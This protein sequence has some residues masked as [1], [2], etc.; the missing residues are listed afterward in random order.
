[1][2][3]IRIFRVVVLV[4]LALSLIAC[5]KCPAPMVTEQFV[6]KITTPFRVT[7]DGSV[8]SIAKGSD[9][10]VYLGGTF[11]SASLVSGTGVLV[12][13]YLGFPLNME[14]PQVDGSIFVATSDGLGGWYIGGD[15]TAVGDVSRER[16]A[17]LDASANLDLDWDPGA[18]GFVY[19][20]VVSG[21]NVYVSGTFT[22]VAGVAQNYF[23]VLDSE[24][25]PGFLDPA[26]DNTVQTILVDEHIYT[27]GTFTNFN[28]Y[29][30]GGIA[31]MNL[32]GVLE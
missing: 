28:G 17:H 4:S 18:D 23:A 15:F 13:T 9:G 21:E 11:T 32:D 16:L 6:E 14:Y 29:V 8:S 5:C 1:M 27:G 24:G 30:R 3:Y 12:D 10:S 7:T 19:D 20:I 26:P 2:Q 31:R 22:S 25:Q